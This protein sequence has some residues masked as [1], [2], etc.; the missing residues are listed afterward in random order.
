MVLGGIFYLGNVFLLDVY[1]LQNGFICLFLLKRKKKYK[2]LFLFCC[3]GRKKIQHDKFDRMYVRSI[4]MFEC[5]LYKSLGNLQHLW[6]LLKYAP[7]DEVILTYSGVNGM[8]WSYE[9]LWRFLSSRLF[10]L[11]TWFKILTSSYTLH[12]FV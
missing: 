5:F 4:I 1:A 6:I 11:T 7:E 2:F 8:L 9:W 3:Y 12:E 10:G